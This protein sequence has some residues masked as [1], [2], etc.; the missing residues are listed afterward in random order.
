VKN[1]YSPCLALYLIIAWRI[2]YLTLLSRFDPN[3]TC[4]PFF[5]TLEWQAVYLIT[6]R[7]KPPDQPPSIAA[8][9]I[10]DSKLGRIPKP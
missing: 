7:E 6:K 8:V 4:E 2:L 3:K 1:A 9:I 5:S 10:D